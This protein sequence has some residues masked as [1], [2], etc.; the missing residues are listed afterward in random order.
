MIVTMATL[1]LVI[2][3]YSSH[4]N[5]L[6]GYNERVITYM[7]LIRMTRLSRCLRHIRRFDVLIRTLLLLLPSAARLLRLLFC[8]FFLYSVLG[9]RSAIV[10]PLSLPPFITSYNLL[11]VSKLD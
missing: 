4:I 9:R 5:H 8:I 10:A 2:I 11:K 7:W 3:V 6:H 1:P